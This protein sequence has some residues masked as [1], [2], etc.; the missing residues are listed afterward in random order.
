M[1]YDEGNTVA[2]R[3]PQRG[4]S[5]K[6]GRAKG[7]FS[8]SGRQLATFSKPAQKPATLLAKLIAQK[9]VV[10]D[11]TLAEQYITYVGHYRLKQNMVRD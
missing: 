9:R 4:G 6:K 11:V 5:L 8:I 2:T 1:R 7:D 3:P 10:S